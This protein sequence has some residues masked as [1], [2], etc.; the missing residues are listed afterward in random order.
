MI[1]ERAG[2]A[3]RHATEE[4]MPRVDEITVICYAR[5]QRSW[6]EMHGVEIYN[7]IYKHP[8]M[9]W[10]EE[11][12]KQNHDLFAQHPDRL[13]VLEG[14]DCIVG[15]VSF[16]INEERSIGTILNNGVIPEHAGNGLGRFMYRHVLQYFRG[17]GVRFAFVETGLDEPHTAARMAYRAVGFDKQ[18]N[19]ALCWQDLREK[20]PGSIP[21]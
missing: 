18:A 1:A 2:F 5:I 11:K 4:D 20:N 8:Q 21:D 13:W 15:Y 16:S 19:I 6:E 7:A 3:L 9:T 14:E 12:T 17:S 10:Q